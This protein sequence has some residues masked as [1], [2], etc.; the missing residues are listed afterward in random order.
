MTPHNITMQTPSTSIVFTKY[1]SVMDSLCNHKDTATKWADQKIPSCICST[2]TPFLG[3]RTQSLDHVVLEGETM[4]PPKTSLAFQSIA[5][6]SLS[7]KIFPP[8]KEVYT[9]LQ[10]GINLW[11]KH[12]GLPA[13]P[14]RYLMTLWEQAWTDHTNCLTNHITHTDIKHFRSLFPDAIFISLF[15]HSFQ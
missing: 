2:L 5:S 3:T 4:L 1:P 13:L 7:N 10:Q 15:L 9:L 11:T 12:H 8:E 14:R 6:G